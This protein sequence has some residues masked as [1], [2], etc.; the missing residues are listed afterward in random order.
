MWSSGKSFWLQIQGFGF[1]SLHY[2]IFWEI[3]GLERGPLSLVSTT[4]ELL[5]RKSNCSGLEN[6][7]SGLR[8]P[9]RWPHDTPLSAK[10]GTNFDDKLR[11]LC[12]YNSLAD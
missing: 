1:D 7:D 9:P 2:R 8:D 12:R 3:V 6:R 5:E 10:V 11:S 4:E